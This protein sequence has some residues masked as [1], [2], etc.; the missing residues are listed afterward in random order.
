[1]AYMSQERKREIA[2]N[3]KAALKGSGLKYSL[4]VLNHS[5]L[6]MTIYSGPVD[7]IGDYHPRHP[8]WN[9][10]EPIDKSTITYLDVNP[11]WYHEHFTGESARLLRLIFS[12]LNEG[13]WDKSQIEVDYH[14]VGWYVDVNVGKWDKPYVLT[15]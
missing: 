6:S 4:R 13:N 3:L 9:T 2:K 14:N 10:N 5:S 11:Y 1:M 12:I 8:S 7:F 15:K